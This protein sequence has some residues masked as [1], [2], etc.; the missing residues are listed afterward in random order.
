MSRSRSMWIS[1][2]RLMWSPIL[3]VVGIILMIIEP[4]EEY[5][6]ALLIAGAI[7]TVM[8]FFVIFRDRRTTQSPAT[9]PSS[10]IQSSIQPSSEG[11]QSYQPVT[12]SQDM[13]TSQP[14]DAKRFCSHCGAD[15]S[16]GKNFCESCGQKI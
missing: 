2:R 7:T 10:Y 11:T 8:L 9:H 4:Y 3:L 12:Q 5:S 15:N 14:T 16:N 1:K 13:Q 6:L